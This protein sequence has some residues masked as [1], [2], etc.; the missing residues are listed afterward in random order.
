M[1]KEDPDG[2]S[3]AALDYL[4]HQQ[5]AH[6]ASLVARGDPTAAGGDPDARRPQLPNVPTTRCKRCN[7]CDTTG[8]FLCKG[9]GQP[10]RDEQDAME[11][12]NALI[13]TASKAHGL[14]W[15]HTTRGYN[16]PGNKY[17]QARR[18][19]KRAK[20]LGY[21]SITDRFKNDPKYRNNLQTQPTLG[22]LWSDDNI[23]QLD[24][25]A[26]VPVEQLHKPMSLADRQKANIPHWR[27][28]SG[29]PRGGENTVKSHPCLRPKYTTTA[30]GG[31]LLRSGPPR[32]AGPEGPEGGSVSFF[33]ARRKA[34][35]ERRERKRPSEWGERQSGWGQQWSTGGSSSS[36]AWTPAT[37]GWHA[38]QGSAPWRSG[39]A[40]QAKK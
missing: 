10:L 12:Q 16:N 30:G 20:S 28:V 32:E 17:N 36:S 26:A 13:E 3:A 31:P 24:E 27:T 29:Q 7:A 33:E 9:C 37:Q 18:H 19:L 15:F 38:D 6:M 2:P 40:W 1:V 14:K 8:L 34:A 22:Q 21:T 11:A 5:N 35:E 39:T 23:G 25:L 4:L